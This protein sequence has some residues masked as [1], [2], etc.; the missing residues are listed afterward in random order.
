[1][2]VRELIATLSHADGDLPVLLAYDSMAVVHSLDS[3]QVI[4]ANHAPYEKAP[5]VLICA[6]DAYEIHHAFNQGDVSGSLLIAN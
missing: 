6:M 5:C 3:G 1:M 2:N 4:L